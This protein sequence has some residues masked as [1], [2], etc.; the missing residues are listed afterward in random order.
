MKYFKFS[1]LLLFVFIIIYSC[2]NNVTPKIIEEHDQVV[3]I[4]EERDSMRIVPKDTAK[5]KPAPKK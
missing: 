1:T 4:L 5:V 2:N 3:K